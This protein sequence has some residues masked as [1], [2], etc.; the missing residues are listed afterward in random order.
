METTNRKMNSYS[1]EETDLLPRGWRPTEIEGFYH[2]AFSGWEQHFIL[3][4]PFKEVPLYTNIKELEV[5][6]QWRL[7][8]SK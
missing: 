4:V 7:R 8:I 5:Y 1:K 2:N 6:V 3:Y